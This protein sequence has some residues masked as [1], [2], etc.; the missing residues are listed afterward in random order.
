MQPYVVKTSSGST[1]WA[2]IVRLSQFVRMHPAPE[3]ELHVE[4]KNV[5]GQTINYD[6]LMSSVRE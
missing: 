4:V 5:G 1:A 2:E 6:L 3:R